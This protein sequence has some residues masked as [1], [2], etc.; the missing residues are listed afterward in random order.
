MS[1][2]TKGPRLFDWAVLPI[3]HQWEEDGQHWLLLRRSLSHPEDL[4][5]Y[6]VFSPVPT[7]LTEMVQ[8]IG[9]RWRIEEDFEQSKDLGLDQYE[10]R[11]WTAWYRHITLVMLAY[12]FLVGVCVK[13][14]LRD[15]TPMPPQALEQRGPHSCSLLPLTTSEVHRL[16]GQLLWPPVCQCP[17]VF[18]WSRWRRSHQSRASFFHTQR[19]LHTSTLSPGLAVT[20]GVGRSRTGP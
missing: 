13:E 20:S 6:L 2:G 4:A 18:A 14:H 7:T 19:R 5:Y 8:A 11:T 3:L 16:L 17:L 15:A 10:V 12:A 1:Q 9:A